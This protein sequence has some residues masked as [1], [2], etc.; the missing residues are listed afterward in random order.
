MLKKPLHGKSLLT[1]ALTD[2]GV[3]GSDHQQKGSASSVPWPKRTMVVRASCTHREWKGHPNQVEDCDRCFLALR[4]CYVQMLV[5][6][7]V[8]LFQTFFVFHRARVHL[9]ANGKQSSL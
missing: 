8:F 6:S 5:L 4:S 7:S 2:S 9:M 3:S 1:A